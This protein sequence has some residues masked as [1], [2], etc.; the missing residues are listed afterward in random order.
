MESP[1]QPAYWKARELMSQELGNDTIKQL[2]R[3][4]RRLDAASAMLPI[5]L[6]ILN[7]HLLAQVS[8]G[9]IWLLLLVVQGWLF[10][11]FGLIA[12][13]LFTHRK[14]LGSRLSYLASFVFYFPIGFIPTAYY[15]VHMRHHR[16]L[17][18]END[19]E[20][21]TIENIGDAPY[22]RWLLFTFIG[23]LMASSYMLQAWNNPKNIQ[24]LLFEYLWY[25]CFIVL[26]VV[27]TIHWPAQMLSGYLLPLIAISPVFSAIRY[28]LEH[29]DYDPEKTM[30]IATC[31]QGNAL[32]H[33]LFFYDSGECHLI[34]H[35]YA[36]I[37]YYRMLAA[38][39]LMRPILI[40]HGVTVHPS[41]RKLVY[42]FL[43][44]HIPVRTPWIELNSL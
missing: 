17:N 1:K 44:K 12:H 39:R 42:A 38:R 29:V 31:Y 19:T 30:Q 15:D 35:L 4:N 26:V 23:Q 5:L 9:I 28:V 2:H 37:P 36:G 43:I 41:L 34:H 8:I 14:V 24:R 40:K 33:G 10:A 3:C 22:T 25:L 27:F 20:M 18:T 21:I 6:A 16:Y 7:F 11:T 32:I 13:E